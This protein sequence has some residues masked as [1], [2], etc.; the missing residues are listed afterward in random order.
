M[1]FSN[2]PVKNPGRYFEQF[3]KVVQPVNG[4]SSNNMPV[5]AMSAASNSFNSSAGGGN[6]NS[7]NSSPTPTTSAANNSWIVQTQRNESKGSTGW[8]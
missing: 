7:N 6:N 1:P 4:A 3:V 5:F 8:N 2:V